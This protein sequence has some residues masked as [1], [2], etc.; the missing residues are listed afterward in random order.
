MTIHAA[1]ESAAEWAVEH[2]SSI[3]ST[4]H[5]VALTCAD[6][7]TLRSLAARLTAIGVRYCAIVE[8]EGEFDGQLCALGILPGTRKEVGRHLSQFPTLK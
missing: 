8:N 6:E 4:T 5:A 3:P 1:G 7:T 2:R